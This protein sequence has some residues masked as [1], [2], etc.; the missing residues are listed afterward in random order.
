M[1][2]LHQIWPPHDSTSNQPHRTPDYG[3]QDTHHRTTAAGIK[4]EI[5]GLRV[6]SG[7]L[8]HRRKFHPIIGPQLHHVEYPRKVHCRRQLQRPSCVRLLRRK[9]PQNDPLP[10]SSIN[11]DTGSTGFGAEEHDI[12]Q[13][14]QPHRR[15]ITTN[16]QEEQHRWTPK[17]QKELP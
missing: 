10:E 11:L 2:T 15:R 1:G 4:E 14:L 8:I 12:Q 13:I 17:Q 5:E 9:A 6:T 7:R 3:Q 16:L